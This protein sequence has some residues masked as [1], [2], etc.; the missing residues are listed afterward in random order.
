M[1]ELKAGREETAGESGEAAEDGAERGSA[2]LRRERA[3]AA[4]GGAGGKKVDGWTRAKISAQACILTLAVVFVASILW[5]NWAP[6]GARMTYEIEVG[7]KSQ[8][9]TAPAPLTPTAAAGLDESGALYQVEEL[10]M[11]TEQVS[12][13]LQYPYESL[14]RLTFEIEYGGDPE[15]L[16]LATANPADGKLLVKPLH[17]RSLNDLAWNAVSGENAILFQKNPVYPDVAS[18]LADREGAFARAGNRVA[19]YY[20]PLEPS[21]PSVD[22]GRADLGTF[23][24]HSFRGKH[25]MMT[26]VKDGPLSLGFDWQDLNWNQGPD[27]LSVYVFRYSDSSLVYAQTLADDGDETPSSLPSAAR[28]CEIS[29]PGLPEGGYRVEMNCGSDVVFSNLSSGQGYLAFQES[30]FLADHAL[31][32]LAGSKPCTVYTNGTR[33]NAQTWHMDA[34]QALTINGGAQLRLEKDNTTYTAEMGNE[35]NEIT[36]QTGDV[37]LS[38]PGA[39]FAFDRGSLFYPVA[40]APYSRLLP[41]SDINYVIAGYTMPRKDGENWKQTVVFDM[42]GVEIRKQTIE[43]IL[44]APGLSGGTPVALKRITAVAEK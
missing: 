25:V 22:P 13:K 18:F 19:S 43:M 17:N 29:V 23:I 20:Y 42:T 8:C 30:V 27:P 5:K 9:A 39:Y 41:I 31:Y 16:L 40:G 1:D 2:R 28:H 26:Y 3:R 11:S 37:T 6:F 7:E 14:S 15:E 36:T 33:L 21:Y 34:A 4:G 10:A 35:V 12:F 44:I 24:G 38:S 32:G